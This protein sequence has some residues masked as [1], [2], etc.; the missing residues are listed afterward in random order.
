MEPEQTHPTSHTI[1]LSSYWLSLQSHTFNFYNALHKVWTESCAGH[2][3][4][5]RLRLNAPEEKKD[6]EGHPEFE[7]SFLMTKDMKHSPGNLM[8]WRDVTVISRLSEDQ[9]PD[10]LS[11]QAGAKAVKFKFEHVQTKRMCSSQ[12][13]FDN[14][15][16]RLEH[17]CQQGHCL[18]LISGENSE[19]H[20]HDGE[21]RHG[22]MRPLR[23]LLRSYRSTKLKYAYLGTCQ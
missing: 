9:S 20:I 19:H 22:S 16:T 17:H 6:E 1:S 5:A 8:K 21:V 15:C 7:C 4:S 11:Q 23:E 12:T 14:I 18:G 13:Y 2:V 10:T 3:H